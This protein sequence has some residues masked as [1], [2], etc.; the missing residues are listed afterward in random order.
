MKNVQE[1]EVIWYRQYGKYPERIQLDGTGKWYVI[2]D[3]SWNASR[4]WKPE[5]VEPLMKQ[6]GCTVDD[7]R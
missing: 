6:A 3:E 2:G 4:P 7:E 1:L 5:I